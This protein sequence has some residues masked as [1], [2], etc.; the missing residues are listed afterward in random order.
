MKYYSPEKLGG[1]VEYADTA[2]QITH[3][4]ITMSYN[5]IFAKYDNE[6][7]ETEKYLDLVAKHEEF[8]QHHCP[9]V[10]RVGSVFLANSG[11]WYI[12][13]EVI[14]ELDVVSKEPKISYCLRNGVGDFAINSG[15]VL[16]DRIYTGDL[17]YV[18]D[19]PKPSLPYTWDKEEKSLLDKFMNKPFEFV[20]VVKEG[21][22]VRESMDIE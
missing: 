13:T 2:L 8:V 12:V 20:D 6:N 7:G 3:I 5:R 21:R 18:C 19:I 4:S 1:Y 11:K 10:Y 14:Y 15:K 17:M 9:S 16:G 22:K